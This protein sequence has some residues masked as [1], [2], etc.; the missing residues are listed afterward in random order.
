MAA[1]I[2]QTDFRSYRLRNFVGAIGMLWALQACSEPFS[3]ADPQ[4]PAD[5]A[6][7]LVEPTTV[8]LTWSARPTNEQ[9]AGYTIYRNGDSVAFV[10]GTEFIERELVEEIQLSYAIASRSE[11]GTTSAVSPAV[12]IKTRDAS[13][14]R[15]LQTFPEDKSGPLLNTTIQPVIYFSEPMDSASINTSTIKMENL[16]TGAPVSGIVSYRPQQAFATFFVGLLPG[17]SSFRITVTKG[18]RDL[19]GNSPIQ[20]YS[21][22]FTTAENQ[23]PRVISTFPANGAEGVPLDVLARITFSEPVQAPVRLW[24]EVDRGR[25]INT[26]YTAG[27]DPATNTYTVNF[28]HGGNDDLLSNRTYTITVG[29]PYDVKDLAGNVMRPLYRFSFKTV[30]IGAPTVVSVIPE[31]EATDVDP[32]SVITVTFSEP[33]DT[34]SVKARLRV[35]KYP[36]SAT[37]DY[38]YVAGMVAFDSSGRIVTFTPAAPLTG[39]HKHVVFLDPGATDLDKVGIEDPFASEFYTRN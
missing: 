17:S 36:N 6:A 5:L 37:D 34:A 15:I 19:A 32:N 23:P 10:A 13:P 3:P 2:A 18:V 4:P 20:D 1:I 33:M 39:G 30:D 16:T 21:F 38:G 25:V 12:S 7:S 29:Y 9:I 31:K 11:R 26:L 24:I 35:Y 28:G 14:P 8:R 27:V 22:T